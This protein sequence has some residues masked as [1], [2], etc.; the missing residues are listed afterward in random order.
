MLKK[1]SKLI[2]NNQKKGEESTVCVFQLVR[3]MKNSALGHFIAS[4]L[5]R[6][7][8]MKT[9]FLFIHS[10]AIAINGRNCKPDQFVFIKERSR[11]YYRFTGGGDL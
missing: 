6:I 9:L 5:I 4:K 3:Q 11:S 7:F 2:K 1:V 8:L 10:I